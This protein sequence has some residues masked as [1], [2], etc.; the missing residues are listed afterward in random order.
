MSNDPPTKAMA[1]SVHTT[2]EEVLHNIYIKELEKLTPTWE[3]TLAKRLREC[4]KGAGF[5]NLKDFAQKLN[6]PCTTYNAYEKGIR[7]PKLSQLA[8]IL[9]ALSISADEF[10]NSSTSQFFL[11]EVLKKNETVADITPMDF[12]WEGLLIENNIGKIIL[13]KSDI[14]DIIE[15]INTD[16]F[17]CFKEQL[18][19]AIAKYKL[20][21]RNDINDRSH[22]YLKL[23]YPIASLMGIKNASL[24]ADT[25]GSDLDKNIKLLA[26]SYFSHIDIS[27]LTRN[28]INEVSQKLQQLPLRSLHHEIDT[29]ISTL[30]TDQNRNNLPEKRIPG[31]EMLFMEYLGYDYNSFAAD[32]PDKVY[33]LIKTVYLY[34]EYPSD[35][36]SANYYFKYL[37]HDALAEHM[38][39]NTDIMMRLAYENEKEMMIYND[40][41]VLSDEE[42]EQLC[43]EQEQDEA[44]RLKKAQEERTHF[45]LRHAESEANAGIPTS[46]P[47]NNALTENGMQQAILAANSFSVESDCL[48]AVSPY[49]RA[50]Q[51][52]KPF[53]EAFYDPMS[54]IDRTQIWEELKE[55]TYISPAKCKNTT[56]EKRK[57]LVENYW[58]KMDPKYVDGP[59]AESFEQLIARAKTV[60]TRLSKVK[61]YTCLLITHAQLINAVQ[62]L[63][64]RPNAS[65]QEQMKYFV[66]LE[67]VANCQLIP[68][69]HEAIL[70]ILKALDNQ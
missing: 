52:A 27:T 51:T 45:F 30:N 42:W 37:T 54:T 31:A 4:R 22:Y 48:I 35:A 64:D 44:L 21:K 3:T 11:C 41:P 7:Q 9:S 61:E 50:R 1:K 33:D 6:I 24:F 25:E 55:F 65:L 14:P 40:A 60:L 17:N 66:Q 5:L 12:M 69:K 29:L 18:S 28:T 53:I 43:D 34:N 8:Q 67:P 23:L 32:H 62:T 20:L 36:I 10:F 70:Q 15:R 13:N 16:F 38:A 46:N 56:V 63:I 39:S 49:K 68:H 57:P 59:G 26:F 19:V 2:T 47:Q 58:K